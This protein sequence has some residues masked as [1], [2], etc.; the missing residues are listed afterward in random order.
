M[1]N[2][3]GKR[4]KLKGRSKGPPFVQLYFGITDSAQFGELSGNALKLLLELARQYRPG[5][6]GDLSIPW[7]LLRYR[8]WKSQGT[9]ARAKNE[10]L[11]AGWIIE[12]RKGGKH[13]CSLYAVTWQPID[14]QRRR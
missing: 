7:S 13:R 14:G 1:A 2:E 4:F 11:Q 5:R 3:T 12:T 6:N 9:V 10:L 8:G